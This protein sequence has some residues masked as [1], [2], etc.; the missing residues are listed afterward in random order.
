MILYRTMPIVASAPPARIAISGIGAKRRYPFKSGCQGDLVLIKGDPDRLRSSRCVVGKPRN[1]TLGFAE[2]SNSVAVWLQEAYRS[3]KG[4]L[5][6][7][8]YV[9]YRLMMSKEVSMQINY[10]EGQDVTLERGFSLFIHG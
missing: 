5:E 6:R 1:N 8:A 4:T 2:C 10:E 3:V 7:S 9:F